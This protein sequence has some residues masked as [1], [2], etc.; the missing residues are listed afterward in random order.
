[1][2]DRR[3]DLRVYLHRIVHDLIARGIIR[4]QQGWT[5]DEILRAEWSTVTREVL[6]DVTAIGVELGA[7]IVGGAARALN[8]GAARI[9]GEGADWLVGT[10]S[11]SR[12]K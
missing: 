1:M 10:I 9:I 3:D 7:G 11:G 8:A 12:K 5:L 6:E 4:R 2:N